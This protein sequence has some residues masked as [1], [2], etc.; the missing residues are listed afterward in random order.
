MCIHISILRSCLITEHSSSTNADVLKSENEDN[1]SASA[2]KDESDLMK[3]LSTLKLAEQVRTMLYE[4]PHY[5]LKAISKR[6]ACSLLGVDKIPLGLMRKS[7]GGEVFVANES[8]KASRCV[9][10]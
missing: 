2:K 10:S 4:L 9:C 6:D 8:S 7:V 5:L 1:T 3:R